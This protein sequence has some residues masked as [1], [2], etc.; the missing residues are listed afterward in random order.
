M[1]GFVILLLLAA[2]FLLMW[3]MVVLR[4]RVRRMDRAPEREEQARFEPAYTETV[5]TGGGLSYGRG[6]DV[7]E[8]LLTATRIGN[9]TSGIKDI[10][11]HR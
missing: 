10:S 2:P 5:K 6:F 7:N 3:W 1:S 9:E 8:E 11:G 4:N